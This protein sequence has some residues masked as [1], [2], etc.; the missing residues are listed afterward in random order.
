MFVNYFKKYINYVIV[1][2]Q[3]TIDSRV[4]VIGSQLDF[5]SLFRLEISNV[6]VA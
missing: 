1:I 4:T 3:S 2:T 5:V 6:V